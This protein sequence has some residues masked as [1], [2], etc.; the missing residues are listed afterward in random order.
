MSKI[1]TTSK[2]Q[3]LLEKYNNSQYVFIYIGDSEAAAFNVSEL[4]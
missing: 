1:I 3:I 4:P 2:E